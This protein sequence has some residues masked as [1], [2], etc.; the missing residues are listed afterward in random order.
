MRLGYL[1]VVAI[2]LYF[3]P[4]QNA[5]A[6]AAEF[7]SRFI[8]EYRGTIFVRG[9]I[10]HDDHKK[11]LYELGERYG[12]KG[13]PIHINLNSKGGNFQEAIKISKILLERQLSTRLESGADC[14]SACAIVFM[15][16]TRLTTIGSQ[17]AREMHPS[18]RLGFHAPTLEI[19]GQADVTEPF[20][21][22]VDA[23]GG[24]LL[25]IARFRGR[26]W[27]NTLIK[28][29]LVNEMML[30]RGR[31]YF[32]IDTVRKAAEFEIDLF[33]ANGPPVLDR[34]VQ[35]VCANVLAI[36]TSSA[37]ADDGWFGA[38]EVK[39]AV[40]QAS[41][42]YRVPRSRGSCVV[43]LQR[44]VFENSEYGHVSLSERNAEE[45]ELFGARPW[46]FWPGSKSLLSIAAQSR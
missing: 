28:S 41:R 10:L 6:V 40:D 42:A 19:R 27:T 34:G 33:D 13:S 31:N 18:A 16:G 7:S 36:K 5:R 20:N 15:A 12:D 32:F 17:L 45:G 46:M 1:L 2:Y 26:Q 25:S 43:T 39:R 35:D 3:P 23:I 38:V 29:E 24:D 14:L 21:E 44:S 30:R 9:E 22:A 37:V 11:L 8:D 4:L